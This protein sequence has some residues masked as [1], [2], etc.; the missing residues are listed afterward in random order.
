MFYKHSNQAKITILA[1]YLDDIII[2][3]NNSEEK[4]KLEQGLMK[5]FAIKNLGRMKSFLGIE[6]AH[7]SNGI[8]L[9]QHKYIIDLFTETGF[10]D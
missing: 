2:I 10:I 1:I 5:E 6:I 3:G 7:S 8:I 9:S 4:D